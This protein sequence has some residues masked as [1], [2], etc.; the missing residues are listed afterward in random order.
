MLAPARSRC[1]RGVWGLGDDGHFQCGPSMVVFLGVHCLSIDGLLAKHRPCPWG[2]DSRDR[3]GDG[4]RAGFHSF[5]A[6]HFGR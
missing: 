6:S 2:T 3:S 1:W 5:G 4:F